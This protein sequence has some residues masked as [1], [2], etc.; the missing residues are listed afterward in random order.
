MG[1]YY[2][3]DIEGKFWFGLQSSCAA[4]RF[5]VIGHP[6][7]YI[8]YYF[9]TDNLEKVESEIKNIEE[10]LKDN[11]PILE[12]FYDTMSIDKPE[13]KAT[14]EKMSEDILSDYADLIL[15]R[16]IRDCIKTKG[17]CYF[18]AEL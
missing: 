1:R 18:D 7:D 17:D 4:N 12:E 13:I 2:S 10:K 6:P 16:K 9:D 8:E 14:V 3:G 5:G 11:L 15:G